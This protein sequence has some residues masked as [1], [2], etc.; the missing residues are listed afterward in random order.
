MAVFSLPFSLPQSARQDGAFQVRGER[1]GQLGM[2]FV[3]VRKEGVNLSRG[4][5][6]IRYVSAAA[7]ES[8]VIELKPAG[9]VNPDAGIIA[10]EI[11][12]RL[13]DTGGREEE[14]RIPLP[15]T[16]GL[17]AI[18]EVVLTCWQVKKELPVDLRITHCSVTPPA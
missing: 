11:F 4:L 10:T 12:T 8:A 13:A 6:R 9:P 7:T 5:L 3:P 18:K 14:I 16:P 15:A 1:V 17:R 2:A